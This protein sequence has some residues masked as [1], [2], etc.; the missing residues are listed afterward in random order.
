M[1]RNEERNKFIAQAAPVLQRLEHAGFEAYIVG[2]CVREL[3]REETG[4]TDIDVTTN[5]LPE[6]VCRVFADM[7]VI[8]TG[9]KHGTVTVLIPASVPTDP[10]LYGDTESFPSDHME[11]A[12]DTPAE[13]VSTVGTIEGP[14]IPIEIT[15]YRTDGTYSDGRHPDQVRFVTSLEEDLAR[16]DFTINAMAMELRGDLQDPFGGREDLAAG[17][18]RAVGDPE[19]RFNEDALRILRALRFAAVLTRSGRTEDGFRIEPAT[20]A[21]LFRCAPLLQ[22]ISVERIFAE[23]KKLVCGPAAGDVVRR[24][25]DI[26]AVVIPE[27]IPMKGFAQNNPYHRYDVLEHCIRAMEAVRSVMPDIEPAAAPAPDVEAAVVPEAESTAIA[28]NDRDLR[29]TYLKLTALLHDIG[30]PGVYTQDENGI[31]HFYGHPQAGEKI[32]RRILERLKADR[33][34]ME[35]VT[36]LIRYHD[37]VFQEDDRLL[38]RWMNRYTTPVLLEILEIKRADNIATG[39][40]SE[41]LLQKFDRIKERIRSIQREADE[42]QTCFC[43]KDLNVSGRDLLEAGIPEGPEIGR[44]LQQLLEEVIDERIPNERAELLAAAGCQTNMK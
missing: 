18:I 13:S 9:I 24:Y 39:N 10:P 5:A 32:V 12:V 15:T 33:F 19:T 16:R 30:K 4:F 3:L 29:L 31:G 25:V 21:A 27:L 42:G 37:L 8:E 14:R 7:P 22:K 38:K 36:T 2:G 11:W 40:V 20:E 26:L 41:D 35:R 28:G 34:T 23:L 43:V 6:E 17:V 1:E 44:I